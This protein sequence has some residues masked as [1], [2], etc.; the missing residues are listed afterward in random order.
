MDFS[1]T[2][3]LAIVLILSPFVL[4][5]AVKQD[6]QFKQNL[7]YIS[8]TILSSQLILGLLNWENLAS[9]RSG[10]E[11]SLTYPNSLL[12][13]FFI[14]SILQIFLLA[15]NKLYNTAVVILNFI[16]SVLIFVGLIRLSSLLGFQA[17]SFAS[18]GAV[19]LVLIGNVVALVFANKDKKL[20]NKYP[21]L[22]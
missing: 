11:L 10:Y 1:Y 5:L 14:I 6:K 15:T 9:G 2:F 22:R 7:K 19:F 13:L 17:V 8:L 21:F 20:L 18:I 3:I 4:A 12:G 16:N